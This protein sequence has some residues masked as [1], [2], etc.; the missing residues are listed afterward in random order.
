MSW[1]SGAT[2]VWAEAV[3]LSICTYGLLRKLWAEKLSCPSGRYEQLKNSWRSFRKSKM[4]FSTARRGEFKDRR[5]RKDRTSC[6]LAK[7]KPIPEKMSSF[8]M[9]KRE[10]YF[11]PRPSR[12]A[13]TTRESSTRLYSKY[14]TL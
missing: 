13:D 10:F 14:R 7:R 11:F 3:K 6:T 8:P 5:T 1:P 9:K 2:K 12:D 4:C